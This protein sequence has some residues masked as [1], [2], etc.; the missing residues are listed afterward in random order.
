MMRKVFTLSACTVLTGWLTG[1]GDS[2]SV[3]ILPG[4]PL[5]LADDRAATISDLRY[6]VRFVVPRERSAPVL[7][8]VV[9]SFALSEAG[10]LVF[11]FAQPEGS[12]GAVRIDGESVPYEVRDEHIVL[13]NGVTD[14]GEI[15]VEIEFVAGD[16]SLNRQDDFL[17]TLFVPDRARVAFPVF[18]QPNLKARFTLELEIPAGWLGVANGSVA[19]HEVQGDREVFRFAETHPISSYLF[20]FAAG[21]FEVEFAKRAG[22]R[23]AMYHRE[24]ERDRIT[25]NR[26]AIFDLHAAALEWLEDYTGIQYPFEKFDFVLIPSF[27]FGGMEHPGAILYGED[28]LLLDESVTQNQL[29]ARASLIAHETAHQWFGDL[30][31]MEWFNDVWMKE[32]LASFLAGK[33]IN[34]TFPDIDHDL[35]FLLAHYPAAYAVDRTDGTHPIRQPLEN[36]SE[37]GTLYGAIIYEKAPIVLKHLERLIGEGALRDGLREYLESHRYGNATW[38]D[39][40]TALDRSTDEDL[41]GWSRIWVEER[42][43]PRVEVVAASAGET[44]TGLSLRQSDPLGGGRLWTQR[45]DLVLGYGDGTRELVPVE[46][47]EASVEVPEAAGRPMPDYILANG[48]GVGYGLMALDPRS[49]DYLL[50]NLPAIDHALT[51]A[52][53]WTSLWEALLEGSVD[54]EAFLDLAVLALSAEPD[55]LNVER[56]LDYLTAAF[57]RHLS[58]ERRRDLVDGLETFLWRQIEAADRPSLATAYFGAYRNV[59]LTEAAMTHLERIWRGE[60]EVPGVPLS[61]RDLTTLAQS[62]ALR[63]VEA[64]DSILAAQRSRIDNADRLAEFDFVAPALSDHRETR[65]AFFASLSDPANRARESWVVTSLRFLHHPLRARESE[66]YIRPSLDLLEEIQRTGDIFFPQRWLGATLAGH[67]TVSAVSIVQDYLDERPDLAPR[68]RGKVLQ[69]AD[70]LVR[71]ARIL[72][73]QADVR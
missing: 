60:E 7:G 11:D 42:G 13:P 19:A 18:D 22:R 70:G 64:S 50:A 23:M 31:T 45:L 55:A 21:A 61:E 24:T 16:G 44:L 2:S 14:S 41:A 63:A 46:L 5:E 68:L 33:I 15:A 29:L 17:Y 38:S 10:P 66:H 54:P 25:R 51:R 57:W 36:L 71:A 62:L 3:E 58:P 69:S 65:D 9:A 40:I 47:R 59:A 6:D 56:I 1:C 48:G 8:R 67:Q 37:A 35:R 20:A 32:T 12:V 28:R 73:R 30:V 49:R 26:D 72:E 27:Q 39:L 43:R 34:P 4:V 53:V 52:I